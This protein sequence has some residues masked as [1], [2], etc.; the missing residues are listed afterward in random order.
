M[1][2]HYVDARSMKSISCIINKLQSYI[3]RL[4]LVIRYYTIIF[5]VSQVLLQ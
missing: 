2:Q 3:L 5:T 4:D 1:Q